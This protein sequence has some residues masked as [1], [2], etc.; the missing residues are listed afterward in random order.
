MNTASLRRPTGVGKRGWFTDEILLST[1][2]EED[3]FP[4]EA[5]A[6]THHREGRLR[7]DHGHCARGRRLKMVSR[8]DSGLHGRSPK[9]IV[10]IATALIPFLKNKRGSGALIG[11]N[12]QRGCPLGGCANSIVGTGNVKYIGPQ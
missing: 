3:V 4:R 12:M 10:S 6:M 1:A 8:G 2:D 9:Q 11:C 7:V 5:Q